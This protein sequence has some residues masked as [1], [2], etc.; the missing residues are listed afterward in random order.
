M[1]RLWTE[2]G[3]LDS[4]PVKVG[5]VV[6]DGLGVAVSNRAHVRAPQLEHRGGGGHVLDITPT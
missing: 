4:D 3:E 2:L 5:D 6:Q 1:Q